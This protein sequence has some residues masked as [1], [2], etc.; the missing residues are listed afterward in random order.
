MGRNIGYSFLGYRYAPESFRAY[1]VIIDRTGAGKHKNRLLPFSS[2]QNWEV[3]CTYI[4]HGRDKAI[5]LIK[6]LARG[7]K[8]FPSRISYGFGDVE[9]LRTYHYIP[10]FSV[11]RDAPIHERLLFYKE[12]KS[13]FMSIGCKI[14]GAETATLGAGYQVEKVS[15][16]IHYIDINRAAVIRL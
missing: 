4:C 5:A 14:E 3:G 6:R 7:M 13:H 1:M 12:A 11:R 9:D 2:E 10:Q 8:C 16:H 15:K